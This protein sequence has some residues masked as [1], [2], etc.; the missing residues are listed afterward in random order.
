MIQTTY[1]SNPALVQATRNDEKKFLLNQAEKGGVGLS[2]LLLL[3]K[4]NFKKK[5]ELKS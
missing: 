3:K 2:K 4:Q 1:I 5:K